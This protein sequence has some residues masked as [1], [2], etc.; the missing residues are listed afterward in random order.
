MNSA[1]CSPLPCI[2]STQPG[3]LRMHFKGSTMKGSNRTKQ[4]MGNGLNREHMHLEQQA[5][6]HLPHI[7]HRITEVSIYFIWSSITRHLFKC[8]TSKE[9]MFRIKLTTEAWATLSEP[10]FLDACCLVIPTDECQKGRCILL[11]HPICPTAEILYSIWVWN[12][13]WH[14]AMVQEETTFLPCIFHS[15]AHSSSGRRI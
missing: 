14:S 8:E 12:Q 11:H 5:N 10:Y 15:A 1:C 9:E 2:P 6:F 7:I 4:K 13:L 3:H